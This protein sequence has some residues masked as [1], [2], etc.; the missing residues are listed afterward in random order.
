MSRN[1]IHMQLFP[2]YSPTQMTENNGHLDQWTLRSSERP[3]RSKTT[4]SPSNPENIGAVEE[5]V[6]M[7]YPGAPTRRFD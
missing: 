3:V 2:I 1:Y 5:G 7:A 6:S 4:P